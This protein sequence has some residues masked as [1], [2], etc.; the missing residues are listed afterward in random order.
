MNYYKRERRA[1]LISA[2]VLGLFII[3]LS[4][5]VIRLVYQV[6]VEHGRAQIE[7]ER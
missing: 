1:D 6:G 4:Y 3:C 5:A 7:S 2:L